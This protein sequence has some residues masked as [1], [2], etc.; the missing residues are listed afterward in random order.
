MKLKDLFASDTTTARDPFAPLDS[1]VCCGR[2]KY[3][4][5][6]LLAK[7]AQNPI[8]Y[9]DDEELDRFKNRPSDS[10]TEEEIEE[11]AGILH[12]LWE[13][14]VPGWVVSLQLRGIELPDALKDEVLMF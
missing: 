9:Y 4:Q 5:K 10:Y 13:T 7:A 12:T 14:D 3:C 1:E 8:E 2:H 11:F 6:E